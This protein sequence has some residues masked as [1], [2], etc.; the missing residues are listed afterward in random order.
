MTMCCVPRPAPIVHSATA[1][2]FASL[3]I[4]TGRPRYCSPR[5]RSGTPA[6]GTWTE[7]TDV[8]SR[9][10]M[11]EGMPMPTAATRVVPQAV[12]DLPQPREEGFRGLHGRVPA[13]GPE[14]R[15]V[16]LDDARQ[17]LRSAD[18]DAD[19]ALSVH[20]RRLP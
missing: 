4:A 7:K 9:W 18:V 11:V 16:A 6:S 8:P 13:L 3:S 14:H 12:D 1:A 2:A 19:G 20:S 17:D 15:P 5:S 10:S